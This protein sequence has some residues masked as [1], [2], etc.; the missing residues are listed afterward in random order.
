MK[1]T[2]FSINPL[3]SVDVAVQEL[4]AYGLQDPYFIEENHLLQIGG[5]FKVIPP[6]LIHSTLTKQSEGIDWN[7][8]WQLHSPYYKNGLLEIDLNIFGAELADPL[9]YLQPGP[10]FGD[11]S[12]ITTRLMLESMAQL[13]PGK[14]VL[15]IGCG[16]GILS[17]AAHKMGASH[18]LGID[19]TPEALKHAKQNALLNHMQDIVFTKEHCNYLKTKELVILINMTFQ[20]QKTVFAEYPHLEGAFIVSGILDFQ[21]PPYIKAFPYPYT[22]IHPVQ[23]GGWTSF[24]ASN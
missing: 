3:S 11:A 8:Q 10:G 12:H 13:V 23:S 19:M 15:D 5:F 16:S 1:H 17:L 21:F 18:V 22:S 14:T 24:I 9:I 7:E 2:I 4:H 20:E 6:F